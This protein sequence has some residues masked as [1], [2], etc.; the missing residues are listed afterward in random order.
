MPSFAQM[1]KDPHLPGVGAVLLDEFHERT[2][3]C[4]LA[5]AWLKALRKGA[6]P[7]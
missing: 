7:D 3:E 4:D 5:L 1:L 2:L 6:R